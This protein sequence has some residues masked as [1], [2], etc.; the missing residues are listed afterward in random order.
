MK[1]ENLFNK[2][3]IPLWGVASLEKT[4]EG[5]DQYRC[6]VFAVPYDP[7]AVAALP[8][9][10]LMNRCRKIL[11]ERTRAVYK[12]IAEEFGQCRFVLYDDVDRELR[13]REKGI[14]QKVVGHLAGLGS[15][16]KSSLLITPAFGPRVRLGTIFTKDDPR[17][18][19]LKVC[20]HP[21]A[22]GCGGC[23]AC[24]EICPAGAIE[25]NGY[26]MNRCIPVVTNA[27]GQY[28]TFCG[29]C[30]QVCP[31]GPAGSGI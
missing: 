7:V 13:L 29:L 4:V 28:K 20:G 12:A 2:Y 23:T 24:S 27:N 10:E 8:D 30:M 14:S 22:G 5:G 6:I 21:P 15:I 25:K 19:D 31:K 1:L 3:K 11:G 18:D 17:E 16:G 9:D 26:N